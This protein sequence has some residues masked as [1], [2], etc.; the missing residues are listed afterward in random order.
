MRTK[1][2]LTMLTGDVRQK[3][4]KLPISAFF[5]TSD[6]YAVTSEKEI[7]NM[8]VN[9]DTVPQESSKKKLNPQKSAPLSLEEVAATGVTFAITDIGFW[10]DPSMKREDDDDKHCVRC[11]VSCYIF[12]QQK[13]FAFE[14]SAWWWVVLINDIPF[15][16][17]GL[18]KWA[19]QAGEISNCVQISSGAPLTST[20]LDELAKNAQA[21]QDD[22][23]TKGLGDFLG[24]LRFQRPF[25]FLNIKD[26][27]TED[28]WVGDNILDLATLVQ[29]T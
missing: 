25:L 1:T 8:N 14:C 16:E 2:H 22:S 21:G 3:F 7:D 6:G 19:Y 13:T 27:I 9:V 4:D 20:Q 23:I 12:E 17:R 26:T 18:R 24:S 28:C 29:P 10:A 5:N 15:R 11:K